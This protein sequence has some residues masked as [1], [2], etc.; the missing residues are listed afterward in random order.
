MVA[1]YKTGN[2]THDSNIYNARL[3]RD[4]AAPP[5]S[6]QAV[7]RSADIIY[8]RTVLQSSLANNSGSDAALYSAMLRSLGVGT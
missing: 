7:F 5:G 8:A 1:P 2:S 3:A 4:V 6:S